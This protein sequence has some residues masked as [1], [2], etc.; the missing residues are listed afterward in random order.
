MIQGHGGDI[1]SLAARLGCAPADIVDMSSNINPLGTPPGLLEELRTHLDA[2]G[3]LPEVDG[4]SIIQ[5]MAD[6]LEADPGCM[7]AGGG[8]TQFIYTTCQALGPGKV[9]IVGPTYADYA[10]AC[11]VHGVEPGHF[12][13]DADDGFELDW[14]RVH[15]QVDGVD[16]VFICNPNNPTG[17][18]IPGEGLRELCRQ[19]PSTRFIIDESYLPFAPEGQAGSMAGCGL[20]N[21]VILWS[22]SKI[23]GIPGLRAGFLI[24]APQVRERYE[25]FMQPWCVNSLAQVA[26]AYL[27]RNKEDVRSFIR[28][29]RE[30]LVAERRLFN[31]R[32]EGC[33]GLICYPSV[34]SYILMRLPR[35]LTA[36]VVCEELARQRLLIRDCSNFYGLSD[37]FVR[38][39]LKSQEVNKMAGERLAAVIGRGQKV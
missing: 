15:R 1:Y 2:A 23:F 31:Q 4:R 33:R 36:G 25:R 19:H 32:L 20:D 28:R 13:L 14:E 18:S 17:G 27:G 39:A 21:V 10:D 11:R 26:I 34:T 6:L 29:T 5:S 3:T 38:V 30:Y 24:A 16:L 35:G 37:R 7:L 9:L 12:L 8:T 22:A